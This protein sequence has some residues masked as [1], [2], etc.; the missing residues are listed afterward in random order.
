VDLMSPR[1]KAWGQVA[2]ALGVLFLLTSF[3]TF[4]VTSG[5]LA[6]FFVKVGVGALLTG[7]WV[8]TNGERL[9]GWARQAFFYSSSVAIAVA[10]VVGLVAINVLV[11][12][13]APSWDLTEKQVYTLSAQTQSTLAALDAPVTAIAFVE[14]EVPEAVEALFLRYHQLNARFTFEFKDPRTSPDLAAKYQLRAGSAV[15][16]LVRG[17]RFQ[18][19]D[20]GR[21]QSARLGEQELTNGLVRVATMGSR[22]LYFLEGHGE[23]SLEPA[24]DSPEAKQATLQVKRVLE[25]EGYAPKALNLALARELPAD[26]SAVVIAGAHSPLSP[27]EQTLLE[28]YLKAG[29]SLMVF[30]EP[31]AALGL[32]EL[33][34]H[35]GV[36]FEPGLVADAKFNPDQPYGV[37]T[38]FFGDHPITR[39]LSNAHLNVFFASTSAITLL[40]QG[41]LPGVK[42][43]PLVLTTPYA[44]IEATP[45]AHPTLDS[46]ERSGQ[47]TLAAVATLEVPEAAGRRSPQGRLL[48]FGDSELLVG[49]FGIDPNRN[50][51]MN[52]FG[53]ATQQPTKLTIRPPD[54]ELSTIELREESLST[55]RLLCLDV[56]PTILIAV[57][58]TV[59]L[60]RR[61]R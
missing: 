39:P 34:G 59:W 38:P 46:G 24:N 56:M 19:L 23:W 42:V 2:G 14:G 17:E 25:D 11:A 36:Q 30:T 16:V 10:F 35:F 20:L 7:L 1:L 22:S 50:L 61:A 31:G 54:R 3:I 13:H 21:L 29:G 57:G 55:I 44:W 6:P 60:S 4:F 33:L 9:S 49:A 43:E 26:A 37:V 47:L 12:R 48:A 51:V 15:A 8:V 40:H 45:T 53:W 41:L 52:A 18:F 28:T 5:S 58:L 32:D 27:A